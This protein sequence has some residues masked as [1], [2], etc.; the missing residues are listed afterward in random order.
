MVCEDVTY[1]LFPPTCF[2]VHFLAAH[3]LK[4]AQLWWF[5]WPGWWRPRGWTGGHR[6]CQ[7]ERRKVSSELAVRIMLTDTNIGCLKKEA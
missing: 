2:A 1:S 5:S 3:F 4:L 7:E 6:G